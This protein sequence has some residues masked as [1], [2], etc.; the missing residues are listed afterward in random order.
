[1]FWRGCEGR[2]VNEPV[3]SVPAVSIFY[4]KGIVPNLGC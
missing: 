2:A 1:M 4:V 3:R